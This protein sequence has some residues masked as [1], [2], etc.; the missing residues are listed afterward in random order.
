MSQSGMFQNGTF[1]PGTVVQELTGQAGGPVFPDALNNINIV[2]THGINTAGNIVPNTITVAIDNSI[3]LGDL[4]PIV[5]GLDALEA[6]TGDITLDDGNI[7]L[8]A[9]NNAG[10][11]GEIR[12]DGNRW[13]SQYGATNTFV[14]QNSGNTTLDVT[15]AISNTAIGASAGLAL[16]TGRY[17]CLLGLYAGT[18]IT[19]GSGC[20]FIGQ[21]A[22]SHSTT[23]SDCIFI[24]SAAGNTVTTGTLGTIGIGGNSLFSLT[25]GRNNVS[26]GDD[27]CLLTTTANNCT[28]VGTN[29]GQSINGDYNNA[30]GGGALSKCAQGTSNCAFGYTSSWNNVFGSRNITIGN[31]SLYNANNPSDCIAIGYNSAKN[32]ATVESRNIVIGE[33]DAVATENGTIRIGHST[34]SVSDK[35]NIFIGSSVAP[36]I[37]PASCIDSVVIGCNAGHSLSIGKL[38]CIVGH[39][40]ASHISGGSS[41]CVFGYNAASAYLTNESSNIVIGNSGTATDQNKI[42][43]GATGS[44]V[45]Q[46]DNC[47][48]AGIQTVN[49]GSV[50]T[51]VSISGDHLGQ[52][53][54][55]QGAGITVTPGANSITI[56][57]TAVSAIIWSTIGASGALVAGHGYICTAGAAL[58]FSLP[59]I[60]A[61][62]DTVALVLDG[63]TSWSITQAAGQSI[64]VAG[65]ATTPGVGGSLTST[66]QGDMLMLVCSVA[67]TRWNAISIIGNITV[68]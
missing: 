15:Q 13:I 26:I 30:F 61:V 25:T 4:T 68:V 50:A 57:A 18:S 21:S 31:L 55:T 35:S 63:S 6:K 45:G 16:T 22:G 24:G 48:I 44:G 29:A 66:S 17:N 1:P 36:A 23:S 33:N 12:F 67:N 59:A 43:I 5:P 27:S 40:A 39:G 34:I 51:V 28:I 62:G 54:I 58:S 52:T 60:S 7:N 20:V 37:V 46:Q 42:R 47:Y 19:S 14:G 8:P 10:T 2:G 53:A 56:A 32:Y 11:V 38:N 3:I 64:L 9:T 41:N 49:V 65:S